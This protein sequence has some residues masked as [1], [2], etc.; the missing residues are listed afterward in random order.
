MKGSFIKRKKYMT[1]GKWSVAGRRI[2]GN[3][4]GGLD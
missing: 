1:L 4:M 3:G 2:K